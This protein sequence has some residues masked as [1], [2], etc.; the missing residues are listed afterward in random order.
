MKDEYPAHRAN[1]LWNREES[2]IPQYQVEAERRVAAEKYDTDII[3]PLQEHRNRLVEE[4]EKIDEN[5]ATAYRERTG[6]MGGGIRTAA[7]VAAAAPKFTRKCQADGCKGWVS[8]SWKCGLCTN[9]TCC[10]CFAVI[11]EHR[12]GTADC[13][14]TCSPDDLATAE[15]IRKSTRPCPKCGEGIEKQ[16]GCDQM[17]CTTCHTPFNWKTGTI[18]TTG[19]IH[20]PHYFQWLER[21]GGRR[22]HGDIPCGGIPTTRYL[23]YFAGGKDYHTMATIHRFLEHVADVELGRYNRILESNDGIQGLMIDY[24][25]NKTTKDAVK[26]KLQQE[27]LKKERARQFY[28]TFQT[29]VTI[30]ADYLQQIANITHSPAV[31]SAGTRSIRLSENTEVGDILQKIMAL[32]TYVNEANATNADTLGVKTP[33]IE[34]TCMNSCPELKIVKMKVSEA[35]ERI[36][37]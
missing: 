36:R 7:A 27:E 10:D 22:E 9:Y 12:K 26:V 2:Y 11:G 37:A 31:I 16:E 6:I 21:T 18:I 19:R 3:K 17:F 20:N 30:G 4:L 34:Y 33:F 15:M 5:I 35:M 23:M 28:D 24:L 25:L 8:S 14:H 13:T 32:I 29:F 1:I